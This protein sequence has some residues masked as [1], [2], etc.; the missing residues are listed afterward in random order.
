MDE[1]QS[2]PGY[3]DSELRTGVAVNRLFTDGFVLRLVRCLTFEVS[4]RRRQDARPGPVKMYRVPPVRAWWPA[5]GAPLERVVKLSSAGTWSE[6]TAFHPVT[7]G[8]AP[9]V[10]RQPALLRLV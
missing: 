3:A 10:C 8:P 6:M 7:L 5:V 1:E 2:K 4:W 9:Q